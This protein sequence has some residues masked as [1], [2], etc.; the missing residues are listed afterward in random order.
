MFV[1]VRSTEASHVSQS[2]A[3]SCYSFLTAVGCMFHMCKCGMLKNDGL[4]TIHS[5]RHILGQTTEGYIVV[6]RKAYPGVV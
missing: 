1:P 2:G 6:R 4:I 3:L 5:A